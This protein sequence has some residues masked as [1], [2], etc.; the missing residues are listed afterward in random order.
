MGTKTGKRKRVAKKKVVKSKKAEVERQTSGFKRP[1]LSSA[2]KGRSRFAIRTRARFNNPNEESYEEL[3]EQRTELRK[4]QAKQRMVLKNHVATLRQRKNSM[5]RG[6]NVKKERQQMGK[7][8]REL[9]SEQEEKH[10]ADLKAVQDKIAAYEEANAKGQARRDLRQ[11]GR[12]HDAAK[13]HHDEDN[14]EAPPAENDEGW[15]DVEEEPVTENKLRGMFAHL[16]A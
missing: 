15:E 10:K 4:E 1:R 9:I 11:L 12:L 16:T 6:E 7:Y 3:L 8:I 13:L 2:A 14:D 5:T